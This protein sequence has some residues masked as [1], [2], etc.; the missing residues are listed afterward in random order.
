[1]KTKCQVYK[2]NNRTT[3]LDKNGQ[4]LM[5]L[6]QQLNRLNRKEE[7]FSDQ[8]DNDM[9]PLIIKAEVQYSLKTMESRKYE[10]LHVL[11]TSV[12]SVFSFNSLR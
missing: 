6:T 11:E 12:K 1:M 8:S 7:I 10:V 5:E 9:R 3:P 2:R 4:I